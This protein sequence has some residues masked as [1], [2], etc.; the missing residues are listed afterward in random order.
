MKEPTNEPSDHKTAYHEYRLTN[1]GTKK[2][3]DNPCA[4]ARQR[5]FHNSLLLKLRDFI[6]DIITTSFALWAE[7]GGK[8]NRP[9][10]LYRILRCSGGFLTFS[11]ADPVIGPLLKSALSRALKGNFSLSLIISTA[12]VKSSSVSRIP[13]QNSTA[14]ARS[15]SATCA[16]RSACFRCKFQILAT[17]PVLR[18]FCLSF[19]S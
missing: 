14:K 5:I 9:R 4:D 10:T 8:P 18:G 7:W 6:K 2:F 1:S 16:N 3:F 11:V 13:I 15:S 19:S 12:F 17:F